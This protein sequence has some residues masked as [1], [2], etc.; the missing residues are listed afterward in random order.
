VPVTTDFLAALCDKMGASKDLWK[1]E[2]VEVSTYRVESF[3]DGCEPD[4]NQEESKELS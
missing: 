3:E 1:R 4:P 2:K